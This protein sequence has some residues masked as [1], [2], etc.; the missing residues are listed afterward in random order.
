MPISLLLLFNLFSLDRG[1]YGM[2]DN[3]L[4]SDSIRRAGFEPV[5]SPLFVRQLHQRLLA[6]SL[7]EQFS[8]LPEFVSNVA[9]PL[10]R[11][12]LVFG[13]PYVNNLRAY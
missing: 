6:T 8:F 13:L 9:D 5:R 11:C 7:L 2:H 1:K 4:R 3:T 12:N 10:W